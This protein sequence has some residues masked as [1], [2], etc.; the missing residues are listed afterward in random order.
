MPERSA[1][2]IKNCVFDGGSYG[3]SDYAFKVSAAATRVRAIG[4]T[5]SNQAD[6]GHTVTATTYQIYG[7]TI[8]G[9]GNVLLTA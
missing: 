6:Y 2:M 3:W 5:F 9:T 1:G 7:L 8:G 4:N